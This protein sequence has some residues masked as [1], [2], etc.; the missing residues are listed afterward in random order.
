MLKKP[1]KCKVFLNFS[2]S[3]PK[4]L[5]FLRC[6]RKSL[7]FCAQCAQHLR[8]VYAKMTQCAHNVHT[9]RNLYTLCWS[10]AQ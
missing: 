2:L 10:R 5:L 6:V 1:N 3:L 9:K 4:V 8:K 7:E